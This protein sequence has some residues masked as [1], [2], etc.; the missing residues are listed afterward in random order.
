[1]NSGFKTVQ[2]C[3][4]LFGVALIAGCHRSKEYQ[5]ECL[6]GAVSRD[7]LAELKKYENRVMI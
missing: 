2:L 5:A 7:D 1:M 3:L 4:A 6:V